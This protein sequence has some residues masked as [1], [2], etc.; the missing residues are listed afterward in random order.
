MFSEQLCNALT[1]D[2][3]EKSIWRCSCQ[4]FSFTITVCITHVNEAWTLIVNNSLK[5]IQSEIE[6][7]ISQVLSSSTRG[8][9]CHSLHSALRNWTC[10]LIVSFHSVTE[11]S[12]EIE[13]QEKNTLHCRNSDQAP[14]QVLI[15]WIG[16]TREVFWVSK[17]E[18]YRHVC[19]LF[20]LTLEYES[21]FL[22]IVFYLIFKTTDFT[23]FML[24]ISGS[25][26]WYFFMVRS[27]ISYYYNPLMSECDLN[28]TKCKYRMDNVYFSTFAKHGVITFSYV[29]AYIHIHKTVT[30]VIRL[31][32]FTLTRGFR[33]N[34]KMHKK[35]T[36][37][38][39]FK[40][41]T[42]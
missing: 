5:S 16:N 42:W 6:N 13:K 2:S 9:H 27:S 23:W 18:L 4:S 24:K 21:P 38:I 32:P 12:P 1:F 8:C 17:M 31:I 14:L 36:A 20:L 22:T 19:I 26:K 33:C 37:T 41:V 7:N 28:I 25:M 29:H 15:L 35:Q 3:I 10:E 39:S 34:V 30:N 11:A 40:V